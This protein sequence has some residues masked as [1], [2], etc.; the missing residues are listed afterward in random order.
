MNI[1]SVAGMQTQMLKSMP[2]N[3]KA[4]K[5]I[6]K[7]INNGDVFTTKNRSAGMK[8]IIKALLVG[9]ASIAATSCA[10]LKG[11]NFVYDESIKQIIPFNDDT[12]TT[13]PNNISKSSNIEQV[14]E[15]DDKLNISSK[16]TNKDNLRNLYDR[17]YF[18]SIDVDEFI[19]KNKD[20]LVG[21]CL[22]EQGEKLAAKITL[23]CTKN[24]SCNHEF[25]PSHGT[26]IYMDDDGNLKIMQIKPPKNYSVDLADYLKTSDVKYAIYLRDFD[27]N[28]EEF[29]KSVKQLDGQKYGLLSAIQSVLSSINVDGG[30]HCSECYMKEIQK[31]GQFENVDANK[32]TPHTLLHLL[33]NKQEKTVDN[34][35]KTI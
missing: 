2:V 31:Y 6:M 11:G 9:A 32:I 26:P 1:S 34:S 17:D 13:K 22:F 5:P 33:V 12:E 10:T 7:Q 27:I 15:F 14:Q 20:K 8:K 24:K 25:T 16:V 30:L 21:S 29:S 23:A 4:F 35:D 28:E 18:K 3:K 19:A